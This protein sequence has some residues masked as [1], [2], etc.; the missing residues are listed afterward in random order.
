MD[1]LNITMS[2]E[3]SSE[4]Y[5]S[6]AWNKKTQAEYERYDHSCARPDDTIG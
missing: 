1:F 2:D 5:G 6:E 3:Q 4:T